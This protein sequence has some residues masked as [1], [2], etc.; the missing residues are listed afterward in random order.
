MLV[1][2]SCRRCG[3]IY[4]A[5]QERLSTPVTSSGLFSCVRCGTPVHHWA[6]LYSYTD[7]KRVMHVGDGNERFRRP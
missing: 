2:F 5:I 3:T 4:S 6:G 1:Y 7:W